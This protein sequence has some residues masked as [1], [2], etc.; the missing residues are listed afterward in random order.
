[1]TLGDDVTDPVGE[2][3][4]TH[5]PVTADLLDK[6]DAGAALVYALYHAPADWWTKGGKLPNGVTEAYIRAC[7]AYRVGKP[8]RVPLRAE[9]GERSGDVDVHVAGHLDPLSRQA[10]LASDLRDLAR[11]RQMPA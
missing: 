7:H 1:M 9:R 3:A 4:E 5:D 6:A 2:L 10:A 11:R 8:G